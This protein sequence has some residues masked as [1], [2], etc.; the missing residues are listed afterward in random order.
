[1]WPLLDL[2]T[3]RRLRARTDG[4]EVGGCRILRRS[5]REANGSRA[6]VGLKAAGSVATGGEAGRES[7]TLLAGCLG[8]RPNKTSSLWVGHLALD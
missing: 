4:W 8:H 3:R 5:L 1:V 6:T 2:R 7:P